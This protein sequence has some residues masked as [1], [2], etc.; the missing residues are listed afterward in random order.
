M[1]WKSWVPKPHPNIT[2]QLCRES[3]FQF[4]TSNATN[5]QEAG[6]PQNPRGFWGHENSRCYLPAVA[7]AQRAVREVA[8]YLLDQ[9]S[10][11]HAQ[12]PMTTMAR[13]R[14]QSFVP[15]KINGEPSV[16]WKLGAF[17]A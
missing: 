11:G 10:G 8:A 7:S 3:C 13:C 14:H 6:A 1:L 12:V 5:C 15:A 2:T 4:L 9:S 17:Q 16:V